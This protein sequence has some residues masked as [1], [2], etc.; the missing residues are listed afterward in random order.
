MIMYNEDGI[1]VIVR[2]ISMIPIPD[3]IIVI[4]FIVISRIPVL[5]FSLNS[6]VIVLSIH[7]AD[8]LISDNMVHVNVIIQRAKLCV[9]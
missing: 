6:L 2:I 7:G 1:V 5:S 8:N 4:V 9:S 3:G